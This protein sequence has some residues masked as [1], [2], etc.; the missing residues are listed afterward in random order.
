MRYFARIELS[1][2]PKFGRKVCDSCQNEILHFLNFSD[3]IDRH[4]KELESLHI[5][6]AEKLD[7]CVVKPKY[8]LNPANVMHLES[9][10]VTHPV[11][12]A[13]GMSDE[14]L[15][16]PLSEDQFDEIAS[17]VNEYAESTASFQSNSTVSYATRGKPIPE[18]KPCFIA[19]EKLEIDYVQSDTES[20]NDEPLITGPRGIKRPRSSGAQEISPSKSLSPSKRMRFAIPHHVVSFYFVSF[21][22]KTNQLF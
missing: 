22:I 19:L 15:D 20:D 1:N 6:K 5:I 3:G 21:V 8:L 17:L 9:N 13:I 10:Q 16:S 14:D 7:E 2:N 12:S 11:D 18:L 4:Q